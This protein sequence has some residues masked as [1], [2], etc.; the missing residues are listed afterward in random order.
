MK[1]YGDYQEYV[2]VQG[3]QGAGAVHWLAAQWQGARWSA[4]RPTDIST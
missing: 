4:R 1:Q 2:K 3:S